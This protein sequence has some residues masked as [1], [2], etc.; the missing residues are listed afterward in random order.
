M[1][2]NGLTN[3][4]SIEGTPKGSHVDLFGLNTYV[5]GEKGERVIVLITDIYGNKYNNVLLI[6]DEFAKAGYY[7]LIPD[8]LKGED[9]VPSVTD[10]PEWLGRHGPEITTPIVDGFLKSLT[11]SGSYS[12]V[13]VVGY[14]FGAKYAIQQLAEG[15]YATAG[16]VAHPSFVTIDE[17]AAITKPIII[18]ASEIDSIFTVELRHETEKKLSEIGA[19]YQI[20]LFS[21]VSHGFT[22]RGDLSDPVVKYSQDKALLDQITWFNLF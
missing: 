8:I 20:D 14:C 7:V 4:K 5:T 16:A 17:V 9:C 6:A 3:R 21:K 13:G 10:I 22:V 18:S 11:E 2:L 19:R 12:F 1:L 15:K